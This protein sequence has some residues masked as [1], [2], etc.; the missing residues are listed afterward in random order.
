M[1]SWRMPSSYSSKTAG[2]AA[3]RQ[4][5][6]ERKTSQDDLHAS[7]F[8]GPVSILVSRRPSTKAWASNFLAFALLRPCV[9]NTPKST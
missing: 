9:P 5:T 2:G 4:I 7:K 8:E 1:D 3:P 6:H